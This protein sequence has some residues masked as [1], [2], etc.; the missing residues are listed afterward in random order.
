[1]DEN[2]ITLL[3]FALK[4]GKVALDNVYAVSDYCE[5]LDNEYYCMKEELAK[6]LGVDYEDLSD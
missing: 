2:K 5:N 3:K 1:M 6:I 4:M